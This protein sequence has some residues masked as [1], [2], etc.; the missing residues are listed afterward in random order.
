MTPEIC[1][2]CG[3]VVPPRAKAC[4]GCGACEETGWSEDAKAD[5]LGIPSEDFDYE[6]Y[7]RREFEGEAPK[8]KWGW[9][10]AVTAAALL[11]VFAWAF[12]RPHL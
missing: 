10:W 12:F 1:P 11:A 6:E 8:R 7:V 2:N 9:V 3:D 4:P 5:S